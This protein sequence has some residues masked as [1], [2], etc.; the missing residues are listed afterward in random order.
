RPIL[1][2][3][4]TFRMRG[5]EEASGTKYVPKELFEEWGRK[6]PV[7]NYEKWLLKEGI[8]SDA[9]KDRVR[10]AIKQEIE[11]GFK[12]GFGETEPVPVKE[13]EEGDVYMA[14]SLGPR[15]TGLDETAR[16]PK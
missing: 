14:T 3:C 16:G 13:V 7:I 2:E 10:G 1:V 4:M 5:H 6:D 11:E 12:G 15:A 8:F 9:E